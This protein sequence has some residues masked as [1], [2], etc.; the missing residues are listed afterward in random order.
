MMT[1]EEFEEWKAHRKLLGDSLRNLHQSFEQTLEA[2]KFVKLRYLEAAD[3]EGCAMMRDIE[4]RVLE[5]KAIFENKEK[6]AE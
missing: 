2:I 1:E 3:F 6:S 5:S 4:K